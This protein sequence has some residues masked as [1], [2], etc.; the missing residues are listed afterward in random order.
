[1]E[2]SFKEKQKIF[3]PKKDDNNN[4]NKND[5]KVIKFGGGLS[6]KERL[7]KMNEEREKKNEANKNQNQIQIPGKVS[8]RIKDLNASVKRSEELK[9]K[10]EEVIEPINESISL[11]K[12]DKIEIYQYPSIPKFKFNKT[13]KQ[14]CKMILMIGNGQNSFINSFINIY[15]K[16]SYNIKFRNSIGKT[17]DNDIK[18]FDIKSRLGEKN[19]DIEIISIPHMEKENNDL[20]KT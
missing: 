19:N 13:Q 1:M 7:K 6:I 18:I 5:T 3:E 14:N 16:I 4:K 11:E 10:I 9:Q 12:N 8:Q 20:K 17:E 2:K 15:S